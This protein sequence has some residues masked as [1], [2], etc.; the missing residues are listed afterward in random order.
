M[1]RR[2]VAIAVA[3]AICALAA[4]A[5]ISLRSGTGWAQPG[6]AKAPAGPPAAAP[7]VGGMMGAKAGGAPAAGAK[8]PL[9]GPGAG[10]NATAPGAA[11]AGAPGPGV[12][13]EAPLPTKA[14]GPPGAAPKGAGAG[15]AGAAA[16]AQPA[17]PVREPKEDVTKYQEGVAG[18]AFALFKEGVVAVEDGKLGL[19]TDKF[20]EAALKDD[21]FAEP[22]RR[23]ARIYASQGKAAWAAEHYKLYLNLKPT[24]DD[25]PEVKALV[26][27]LR[28]G[29]PPVRLRR[30]QTDL[31]LRP[32]TEPAPPNYVLGARNQGQTGVKY[33]VP[34]MRYHDAGF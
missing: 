12:Q 9:M 14:G 11:K 23:L 20:V 31:T 26:E 32:H 21:K 13:A 10:K 1:A 4:I 28:A 17:K 19:A 7:K 3:V 24:A 29:A 5:V 33:H 30:P 8:S 18:E 16:P 15:A 2:L 6:G 34:V 25:A 22:H 27:R